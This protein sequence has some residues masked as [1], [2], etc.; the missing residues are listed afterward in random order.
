M[1]SG[2]R[3]SKTFGTSWASTCS[4]TP[5]E[6]LDYGPRILS[7]FLFLF[8]VFKPLTPKH[9]SPG[10]VL[11]YHVEPQ[12]APTCRL[13]SHK[14]P[15]PR[16]QGLA[17]WTQT[18]REPRLLRHCSNCSTGTAADASG[19]TPRPLPDWGWDRGVERAS[20]LPVGAQVWG[21]GGHRGSRGRLTEHSLGRPFPNIS[22]APRAVCKAPWFTGSKRAQEGEGA[23]ANHKRPHVGKQLK[24]TL[25]STQL[26][27]AAGVSLLPGSCDSSITYG[28]HTVNLL[29]LGT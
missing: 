28:T 9:E 1:V 25:R 27:S 21:E 5:Y 12:G 18:R 2:S 15:R 3:R 24:G 14:G 8:A 26:G 4:N 29:H 11:G 17:C 6:D 22:T 19:D 10:R 23:R 13:P 7:L 20:G 16:A